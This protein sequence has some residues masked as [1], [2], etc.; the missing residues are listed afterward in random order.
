MAETVVQ[1]SRSRDL[2]KLLLRPGNIIGANF[3][4]GLEVNPLS[5]P[6]WHCDKHLVNNFFYYYNYGFSKFVFWVFIL[7][8]G[9]WERTLQNMQKC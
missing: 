2:D 4:P 9:S 7:I 8:G 3:D 1:P 5:F 6:L